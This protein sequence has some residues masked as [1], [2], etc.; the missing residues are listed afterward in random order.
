MAN[1]L[2]ESAF[3]RDQTPSTAWPDVQPGPPNMD[4]GLMGMRFMHGICQI[5]EKHGLL[6]ESNPAATPRE[7]T[8]QAAI[9]Q[10]ASQVL[11][12]KGSPASSQLLSI[13]IG[14]TQS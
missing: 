11:T 14:A 12:N 1:L 8:I 13:P 9:G 10:S 2:L 7:L 3:S 6:P 5:A 4:A